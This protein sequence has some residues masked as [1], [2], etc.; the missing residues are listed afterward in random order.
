MKQLLI[1]NSSKAINAVGATPYDL[2]GLQKG[3]ITFWE[4]GEATPLSA[5][6]TK[7]FGIAIGRGNNSPAFVIPEVDINTLDVVLSEPSAG[8]KFQAK[9][10]I[11]NVTAGEVY[12]VVLAK[13]NTVPHERN[14]WTAT[15]T[16]GKTE[17]GSAGASKVADEIAKY[18]KAQAETGS[19]NVEVSVSSNVVTFKGTDYTPWTIK[20]AD[21]IPSTAISVTSTAKKPIGD[22]DYVQD[23]ASRCAAGKGFNLSSDDGKEIYPGYPE[24]VEDVNYNIY[25]LHFAT[26][27][28][29]GKQLNEP[30]WQYVHIAVPVSSSAN[31]TIKT[32]LGISSDED[33]D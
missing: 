9:I 8:V 31:S 2:S 5:K 7:N 11:P 6:A 32:I 15:Y 18:Y 33:T 19:L 13:G 27:R 22:K 30:V 28:Q 21:S 24:E 1:V 29:S 16:T 25:N 17:T 12:T 14:T 20:S 3:A 10:T 4:L 23:L 26:I